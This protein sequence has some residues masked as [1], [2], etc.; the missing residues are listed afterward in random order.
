[1]KKKLAKRHLCLLLV[2]SLVG[3]VPLNIPGN[4][5]VYGETGASDNAI[6]QIPILN[7]PQTSESIDRVHK[8]EELGEKYF[9]QNLMDKAL[10]KWQEAYGMSIEMKYTEGEG[11]APTNMAASF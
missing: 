3:V 4:G 9:N 10:A 8:L 7:I 2:L 11:S 1:M 5:V 6:K